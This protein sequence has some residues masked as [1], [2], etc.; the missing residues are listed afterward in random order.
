MSV[1][2]HIKSMMEEYSSAEK[3]ARKLYYKKCGKNPI[4]DCK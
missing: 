4:Y 3:K 1:I 2:S